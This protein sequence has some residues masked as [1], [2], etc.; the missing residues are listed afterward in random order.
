MPD[1]PWYMNCNSKK[2]VQWNI[3]LYPEEKS[4]LI[5]EIK[6]HKMSQVG[7]VRQA[8]EMLKAGYF[9]AFKQIEAEKAENKAK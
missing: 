7:F 5:A 6:A 9:D 2:Y 4:E 1:K 8:L 3:S